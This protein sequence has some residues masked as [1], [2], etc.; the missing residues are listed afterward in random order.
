MAVQAIISR[1]SGLETL[2][3][4]NAAALVV[5]TAIM[6]MMSSVR[7]FFLPT[8]GL[9]GAQ[10]MD[11]KSEFTIGSFGGVVALA[12]RRS[13]A[14]VNEFEAIYQSLHVVINMRFIR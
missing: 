5:D 10:T 4:Y 1:R 8:L 13:H 11:E 3:I 14:F 12:G 7:T 2:G 6:V 9:A